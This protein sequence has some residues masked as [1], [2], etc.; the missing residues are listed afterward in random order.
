MDSENRVILNVGGIRHETYKATLKKIPATRL[1]KLTEAVANYDPILNEYFFD[2]HPGVFGQIL[3]YYRT[4]KLHYPTDVCG[5]LF[6]E[7]LEFWGLDANQVEP[8][9]W[10]TYTSHRETQE[11]LQ[12]LNDLD[13][14]TERKTEEELYA[15]FGFEDAYQSG[16]LSIWQKYKPKIWMLFDESYSSLGAKFLAIVSVFFIVLS[17]L[18]FCLKTSSS[19][20]IPYLYN[21]SIH[22]EPSDTVSY[23]TTTI[24][25]RP[26]G[27]INGVPTPSPS[28]RLDRDQPRST[29][30]DV[31]S[32]K[33]SHSTWTEFNWTIRKGKI[34]AH[35]FFS[36]VETISNA[37]FTFEIIIRFLVTPSKLEFIKSPVNIIDLL[38]LISFYVDCI[39]TAILSEDGGYEAL[40]FFSII[41]IM[42]L[43][44]LT[45][46]IAGLKILIHT[47]RASLK[48]LVLLVFF[49]MVFIVIFAALMYHAERFQPSPDNDFASIPV[50]LWWAIVTMTTV[51][52]G[53]QVPKTYLGMVVG[54][55]CAI[56]GV[57]TISLPVPVIVSNFSRFYTHTQAQSKL[58]KKRRRVLPVEAV[59][60]K[61]MGPSGLGASGTNPFAARSGFPNATHDFHSNHAGR[62]ATVEAMRKT[63]GGSVNPKL[64]TSVNSRDADQ[65]ER[66]TL[67]P[68]YSHV[69]AR[70]E[71][72]LLF[73][74]PLPTTNS[75]SAANTNVTSE[76]DMKPQTVQSDRKESNKQDHL[77]SLSLS[78]PA[79][80]DAP[81]EPDLLKSRGP[82]TTRLIANDV[83]ASPSVLV[84]NT[85]DDVMLNSE[86]NLQQY[87]EYLSIQRTSEITPPRLS[88][89]SVEKMDNIRTDA[90][91]SR[92][93]PFTEA[94]I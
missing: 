48:E 33:G 89:G 37:W 53:D 46:H 30:P 80:S 15:K 45:R 70:V 81:V 13:L 22:I 27:T 34:R 41:R 63:T 9:C 68:S 82:N 94:R 51:G 79:L 73:D 44:K 90:S 49:L 65:T 76:N 36:Y 67:F 10:M 56:T 66:E 28:S 54:A 93:R 57:M 11:T 32:D 64:R 55:M 24:S 42:R 20:R 7:E 25:D 2:R 8:C 61:M 40:E 74:F 14:D 5:P 23:L 62:G 47:F 88:I 4:G 75:T 39:I 19:L 92:N 43:F 78:R 77:N 59:R 69:E 85:K 58:P 35:D 29:A 12:I 60:P 52:Y 87:D 26:S 6:E 71:P 17:I 16:S 50:G 21:E 91:K 86:G 83:R 38:A 84:L 31:H 1:S 3:N 72:S 18:S